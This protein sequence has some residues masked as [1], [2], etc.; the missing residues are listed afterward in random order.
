MRWV[1]QHPQY[2]VP[3]K[4]KFASGADGWLVAFAQIHEKRIV[5]LEQ[6]A[7]YSQTSIKIPDVCSQFGVETSTPFSML[8][9][10]SV[11]LVNA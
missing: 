4:A 1:Q 6:P 8:R 3:A 10:L 7:P 2:S 9:S 11:E 5:T